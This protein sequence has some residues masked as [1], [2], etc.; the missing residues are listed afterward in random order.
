[1]VSRPGPLDEKTSP[2]MVVVMP[3]VLILPNPKSPP[4]TAE[5][6]WARAYGAVG[7]MLDRHHLST[8]VESSACGST[9]ASTWP[10]L[11][12]TAMS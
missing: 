4:K 1:M 2:V 3:D 12:A 5:P 11:S 8:Y 10:E 7:G 6:E 9:M